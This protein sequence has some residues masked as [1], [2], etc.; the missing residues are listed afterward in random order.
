MK[1]SQAHIT[2]VSEF[3]RRKLKGDQLNNFEKELKTNKALLKEVQFQKS[4]QSAVKLSLVKDAMDQAKIDALLENKTLHPEYE[5]IQ[6]QLKLAS[7]SSINKQKQIRRWLVVGLAACLL[8]ALPIGFKAYMNYQLENSI[9]YAIS[10]FELNEL[11]AV[12]ARSDI[13]SYKINTI[14]DAVK[15]KKWEKAIQTV[16]Q[17]E[18]QFEFKHTKELKSWIDSIMLFNEKEYEK[19][20]ERLENIKPSI[21]QSE[22]AI[23]NIL[24]LSYLKIKNKPKAREQYNALAENSETCDSQ[25]VKQ[26]K[27]Y[28][29]L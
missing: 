28:F 19:C 3:V 5:S 10:S 16:N 8:L 17:L 15:N 26:L 6:E 9:E 11:K 2:L 4:I 22:C 13:I 20:I 14:Q 29:I 27:K 12:S 7:T 23:G 18:N 21:V 25:K 24:A 1:I